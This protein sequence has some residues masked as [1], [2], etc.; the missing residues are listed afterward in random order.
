MSIS[1]F[2]E[3]E[4]QYERLF[5]HATHIGEKL[6]GALTSG[7]NGDPTVFHLS[8]EE[9]LDPFVLLRINPGI[10]ISPQNQALLD[11]IRKEGVYHGVKVQI[12][13]LNEETGKKHK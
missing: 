4:T 6:D 5:K 13:Q 12:E 10:E 7:Q 11:Q 8:T 2:V 1:D 9:G 3:A